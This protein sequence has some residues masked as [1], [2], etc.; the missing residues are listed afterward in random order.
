MVAAKSLA[1]NQSTNAAQKPTGVS[2]STARPATNTAKSRQSEKRA[3]EQ[4]FILILVL[5]AVLF[6]AVAAI[7]LWFS[8]S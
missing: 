5:M 7:A 4:R 2:G 3:K 1:K 6:V 8:R